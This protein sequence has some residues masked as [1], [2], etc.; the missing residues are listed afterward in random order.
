MADVRRSTGELGTLGEEVAARHLEALGMEVLDRNWRCADGA[1][2]GELDIVARDGP[3]VVF[4]EVKARRGRSLGGPLASITPAKVARL[5]R[6]A[7]A[8][9]ARSGERASGARLDAVAVCWP[10]PGAAPEV[11]HLRGIG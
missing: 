10:A 11:E 8:W 3:T 5:R 9:L 4:V 2:R 6:L 7:G 1:L